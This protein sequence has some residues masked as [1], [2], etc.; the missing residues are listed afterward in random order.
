[1]VDTWVKQIRHSINGRDYSTDLRSKGAKSI[2]SAIN[3]DRLWH[4]HQ[5]QCDRCARKG[6]WAEA[7]LSNHLSICHFRHIMTWLGH[8]FFLAFSRQPV[9][10]TVRNAIDLA[11]VPNATNASIQEDLEW[12]AI[13]K[14]NDSNVSLF[15]HPLLP[16]VRRRDIRRAMKRLERAGFDISQFP[17]WGKMMSSCD[18]STVEQ[19][20]TLLDQVNSAVSDPADAFDP[21]KV[22]I[23][24]NFSKYLNKCI[25]DWP[26]RF[27]TLVHAFGLVQRGYFTASIDLK[28]YFKQILVDPLFWHYLGFEYDGQAY[29]CR[30]CP[31]GIKIG[32][33]LASLLTAVIA[34]ILAHE[35]ITV[36]FMIDD[37]LVIAPSY[38]ECLAHR[39]R[40]LALLDELGLVVN[41]KK[42][43]EPSQINTF[44][45]V[46]LDTVTGYLRIPSE[47]LEEYLW[48]AQPWQDQ[49]LAARGSGSRAVIKTPALEL[50][51]FLGR[52]ERVAMV[53]PAGK[54]YM[55]ALWGSFKYYHGEIVPHATLEISG[56][57][58]QE[59]TWWYQVLLDGASSPHGW[60]YSWSESPTTV[61]SWSDASGSGQFAI[62]L[63]DM[64]LQGRVDPQHLS[65]FG[66]PV[67]S[68]FLELVPIWLV[69]SMLGPQ[70]HDCLFI[71]FTD[72]LNNARALNR[73]R[74]QSLHTFSLLKEI[75]LLSHAQRVTVVGAWL[76]RCDLQLLDDLSKEDYEPY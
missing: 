55:R 10:C 61:T 12:H 7:Y 75:I 30:R 16:V 57:A 72:N 69:L 40:V 47:K 49:I 17:N 48:E 60:A 2:H 68:T 8:G 25:M 31:F 34:Q 65:A 37:I 50:Q 63:G 11:L 14:H 18:I 51:S 13:Q 67:S 32:P 38:G 35:H 21:I 64:V 33:A 71:A 41:H 1:M 19:L 46:V 3:L 24:I 44:L 5:R 74:C 52:C 22:R 28:N 6:P 26:F 62:I 66:K 36:V 56:E 58:I 39:D 76:P 73:L 4:Y 29:S 20:N 70:L 59:F 54:A 43:T 9:A 45:G 23:C 15:V 27:H 53:Y 42:T